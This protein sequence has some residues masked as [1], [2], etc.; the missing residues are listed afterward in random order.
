MKNTLQSNQL[1]EGR[2][3]WPSGLGV[4]CRDLEVGGSNPA[5]VSWREY[6]YDNWLK[7]PFS[8]HLF[9]FVIQYNKLF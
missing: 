7:Q 4:G 6:L 8:V 2:Q 5:E 9:Y 3:V 1:P